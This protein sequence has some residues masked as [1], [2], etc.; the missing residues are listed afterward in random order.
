MSADDKPLQKIGELTLAGEHYDLA[1][2]GAYC[3]VRDKGLDAYGRPVAEVV[4]LG[5]WIVKSVAGGPNVN[6]VLQADRLQALLDALGEATTAL[7]G[8]DD[9]RRAAMAGGEGVK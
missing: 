4:E 3:L 2:N 6:V 7:V 9:M 1:R 8:K 5:P